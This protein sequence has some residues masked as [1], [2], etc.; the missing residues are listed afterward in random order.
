MFNHRW[1]EGNPVC[2]FPC[3]SIKMKHPKPTL[4]FVMKSISLI[5]RFVQSRFNITQRALRLLEAILIVLQVQID[6]IPTPPGRRF[7]RLQ[8][9][10]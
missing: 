10:Q 9:A 8:I 4:N 7:R 6:A 1:L 2:V 3:F 5:L